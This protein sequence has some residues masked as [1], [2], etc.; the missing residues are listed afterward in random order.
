MINPARRQGKKEHRYVNVRPLRGLTELTRV[1]IDESMKNPARRQGK[2][3]HLYVDVRS[4]KGLTKLTR[5]RIDKRPMT[6]VR[7]LP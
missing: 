5:V 6:S 4:L 3:E 7:V 2:K 1:R